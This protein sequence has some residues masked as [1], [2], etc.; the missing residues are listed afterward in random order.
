MS[1]PLEEVDTGPY[2]D[3]NVSST[4]AKEKTYEQIAKDSGMRYTICDAPPLGV[5]LLVGLQHL[6]TMRGETV[7]IPLLITSK[8]GAST[9]QAAA[10]IA[11]VFVVSG[12][13]TLVQTSIGDRLPIIQGGSFS[14]LPATFSIIANP[15]LQ[16]ITDSNER[17]V[18]TMRVAQGAIISVGLLQMFIG[19]TGLFVPLIRYIGPVTIVPVITATGLGLYAVAFKDISECWAIG[20]TQ[21]FTTIIFSQFL[22]KVKIGGQPIF[23]LFPIVLAIAVSWSLDGILTAS[24]VWSEGSPCGIESMGPLL[25]ETPWV[26]VPYPGQWGPPW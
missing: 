6:L 7:L 25:S 24:G 14:Y 17:F 11:T 13:N 3:M 16:A 10:V 18:E 4:P 9:E 5:S 2:S 19:Y 1:Q 8:M 22:K 20:L 23:G 21:M 15:T 26:R 12:I